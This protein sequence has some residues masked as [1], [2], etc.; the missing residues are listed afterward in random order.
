MVFW[1]RF[2]ARSIQTVVWPIAYPFLKYKYNLTFKGIEN[3]SDLKN[4]S[5]TIAGNISQNPGILLV[6]NHVSEFDFAFIIAGFNPF[7]RSMPLFFVG[8]SGKRYDDKDYGWRRFLYRQDSILK[9]AG[10]Y[11]AIRGT[12]DYGHALQTHIDLLKAGCTVCIF[13]HGGYKN[14]NEVHGGAG[15]LA[16]LDTVVV[17][18]LRIEKNDTSVQV[19]FGSLRKVE[20]NDIDID[21]KLIARDLLESV[22]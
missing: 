2:L 20:K 18:P 11:P 4:V 3:I 8:D 22:R 13:P 14:H 17:L 6:S 16:A 19:T 12:G 10:V 1:K 9:A 5:H 21:Y 15:F 7:S